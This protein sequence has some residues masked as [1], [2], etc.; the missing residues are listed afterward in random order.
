MAHDWGSSAGGGGWGTG[1][2]G[3][4]STGGWGDTSTRETPE[5][6]SSNAPENDG[7][8]NPDSILSHAPTDSISSLKY[9]PDN[10]NFLACASW[11][12]ELSLYQLDASGNCKILG[13]K[14]HDA[15]I[16]SSNWMKDKSQN[17]ISGSCDCTVQL[18]DPKQ[19]TNLVVGTVEFP[20]LFLSFVSVLPPLSAVPPFFGGS[21]CAWGGQVR[22]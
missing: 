13:K 6:T 4:V 1:G 8:E 5:I 7:K 2:A 11:N 20:L 17:L 16:L 10:D 15:P 21:E 19:D 3:G 12:G 9:S 22:W 14:K 18:W